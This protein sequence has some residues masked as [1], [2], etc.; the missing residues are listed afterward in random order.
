MRTKIV[1]SI[2]LGTMLSVACLALIGR[3][4]EDWVGRPA[5]FAVSSEVTLKRNS[6]LMFR[7]VNAFSIS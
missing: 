2:G 7:L 3:R 4:S 1:V 6:R 5:A